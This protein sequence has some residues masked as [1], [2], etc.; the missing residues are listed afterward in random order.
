MKRKLFLGISLVLLLTLF[1]LYFIPS[2]ERFYAKEHEDKVILIAHAGGA[3]DGKVYT[4]S[5]EAVEL[6]IRN[7][8]DFIEL[9]LYET[10]DK[11]IGALHNVHEFN[12]FT[13]FRDYSKPLNSEDFRSRRIYGTM[14]PLLSTDINRLFDKE[15]TYLVTDKI[16][17]FDLLNEEILVSKELLLVEVFTYRS[18][19]KALRKGI[20]H[21]MLCVKDSRD[22]SLYW[23]LLITGKI[24]M[25]TI[26][27]EL[28]ALR[29]DDLESL[30]KRGVSIFAFTSND[31]DYILK[32]A[33]TTVSGFYTDSITYK[34]LY[35]QQ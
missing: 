29:Q 15:Q 33:G 24:S 3:I 20:R 18:Y 27:K 17:N 1:F 4:N 13:G 19:F 7:E 6:S 22:L 8:Y 14:H 16:K 34:D 31:K 26:P 10:E 32:H 35:G 5:L 21:P 23:P 30:Y 9:D 11:K 28:I 2:P 12:D 25:I